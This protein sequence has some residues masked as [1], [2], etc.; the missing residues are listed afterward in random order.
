MQ[1]FNKIEY[2]LLFDCIVFIIN[3]L[4]CKCILGKLQQRENL[5]E[6]GEND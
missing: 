1:S 2:I 3:V 4:V 5:V 6:C